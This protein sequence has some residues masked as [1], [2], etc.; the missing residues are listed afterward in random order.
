MFR[1]MSVWSW[2]E[3]CFK[4]IWASDP[5]AEKKKRTLPPPKENHLENFSGLK[6]KLSR[7]AVDTKILFKKPGR[8]YLLPKS[9]LCGPRFFGAKKSSSL[10]QGSVCFFYPTPGVVRMDKQETRQF[11]HQKYLFT[12]FVPLNLPP[13]QP[14]K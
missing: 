10:E 4:G 12:I 1:D 14:A 3:P 11:V 13:S 7:P 8:P 5:F 9:F 6:E 2:F